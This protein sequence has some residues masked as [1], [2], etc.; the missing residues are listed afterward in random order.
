MRLLAR[1]ERVKLPPLSG[2]VLA[3]VAIVVLEAFNPKT[4]GLLHALGGFR[5]ELQ[6]VPF[7]F[8]GYV[9]IRSK[10]RLRQ[11][12]IILGVI[13]LAN[14]VVAAYQT[15]LSPA[16]LASWGPGLP[17]ARAADDGR[18]KGLDRAHLL[19]AKA[20]RACARSASAPTA[21][22]AAASA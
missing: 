7:F 19:Q 14:G 20:K 3:F 1:R 6:W 17:R 16:Q 11:L 22:S 13:G 2:W 12:F 4:Q 10:K 21:A 8:F 9:L 18:Q 15:S 5:Q